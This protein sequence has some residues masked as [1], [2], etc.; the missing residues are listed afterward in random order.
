MC[1]LHP[2]MNILQAQ[3]MKNFQP[4][5]SLSYAESMIA[6]YGKHGWIYTETSNLYEQTITLWIQSLEAEYHWSIP[7]KL[8]C[9]SR[10][11]CRFNT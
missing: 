5:K 6:Y 8:L 11:K 10:S 1:K 2:F 4:Q 9:V 7:V 3:F